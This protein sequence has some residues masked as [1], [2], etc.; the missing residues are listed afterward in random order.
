MLTIFKSDIFA[1]VLS[2]M[3]LFY[4]TLKAIIINKLQRIQ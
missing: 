4:T 3:P 2:E 1:S